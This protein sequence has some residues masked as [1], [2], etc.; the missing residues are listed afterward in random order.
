MAYITPRHHLI[1]NVRS[2]PI[3]HRPPPFLLSGFFFFFP[4]S[5]GHGAQ[6]IDR[7]KT[8]DLPPAEMLTIFVVVCFVFC[9]VLF[10][11]VVAL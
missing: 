1:F 8:S 7:M 5:P 2:D 6:G 4:L 9:G 10:S 3:L 11:L